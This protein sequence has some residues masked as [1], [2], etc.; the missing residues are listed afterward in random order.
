MPEQ[1]TSRTGRH[2]FRLSVRGLMILV[3]LLGGGLGWFAHVLRKAQ[4]QRD[5]VSAIQRIGGNVHYESEWSNATPP[6]GTLPSRPP[7]WPK[8]LVDRVGTDFFLNVVGIYLTRGASDAELA[9]LGSLSRLES[10]VVHPSTVTDAGLVHL[11][12]L[13]HLSNLQLPG[14]R[15][16]GEGMVCLEG[17]TKLQM[18]IL[19][20]T[21]VSDA[22][23]IHLKGLTSLRSLD[24]SN[25]KVTDAGLIHLKG[26]NNLVAFSLAGT[27]VSDAGLEHLRGLTE[28]VRLSLAGTK[29]TDAGVQE[30]QKAI[31]MLKVDR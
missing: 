24:L 23:L 5:A 31:P 20:D 16:G 18:L 14:S 11:K 29:V 27:Q 9:Y 28:L 26:L 2:R 25:T 4:A 1:P 8:W 15:V 19:W 13:T 17:M 12:G 10:L 6:V 22:G 21:E 30:L 7:L 3:L